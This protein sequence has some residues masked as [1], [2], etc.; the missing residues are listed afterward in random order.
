M[1]TNFF[2]ILLYIFSLQTV[3]QTVNTKSLRNI[4][5]TNIRST[6]L[7]KLYNVSSQSSVRMPYFNSEKYTFEYRRKNKIKIR[8]MHYKNMDYPF[9]VNLNRKDNQ[10]YDKETEVFIVTYKTYG[11]YVVGSVRAI[12]GD[13]NVTKE[14]LVT[15]DMDGNVIDYIPFAEKHSNFYITEGIIFE[16]LKIEI[17][18]LDFS[19]D[20]LLDVKTFKAIKDMKGQRTDKYYQITPEG[21]FNLVKETHYQPQIYTIN[22]L[23]SKQCISE[24]QEKILK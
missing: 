15:F 2:A 10:R 14:W 23:D 12:S 5:Y 3:A 22:M 11:E 16:D 24:R 7:Q 8:T 19:E 9:F 1:K 4:A 13:H 17:Q 20:I 6:F 18:H 21:K